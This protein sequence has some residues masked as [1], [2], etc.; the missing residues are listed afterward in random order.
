MR[1]HV[2][3]TAN[4]QAFAITPSMWA[5]ADGQGD[6]SFGE[7]EAEFLA[8][9]AEAEVLLTATNALKA[10]YPC[11]SPKLKMIFCASA[12]LDR[13]APFDWLPDGVA[14]LNN[15]GVHG[16]RAGEY[17]AMAL[18]MLAGKMPQMIA[19]QHAGRW[20]KHYASVLA[21]RHLTV[22]GTGDLG[23]SGARLARMFGMRTTGVRT[24]AVAHLD[25]DA[26]VAVDAI[27]S[28]LPQTD[29]LLL[30][31][32]LT[33]ETNGMIDRRRLELLPVGAGVI[34][35][36]RGALLE[37]DALC[38]LLDAGHLGGAVLDVFVPEPIPTGHRLW[39]TRNLVI[40]PH[41]AADDPATY[42]RHSLQIF[43]R[44]LAAFERGEPLPN[45]FD[46]A[47]G[48]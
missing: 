23:S 2:Q 4:D 39:T 6:V 19:A 26:V 43:L 3:N 32:P 36:G 40:T 47:R 27:D 14:L 28:V 16:A 22:V 42:A 46:T 25:F 20:E 34:N 5:A 37:Q 13:L 31:A 1:I 30:A 12:G 48:Y 29:F 44:N 45:R 17:A 24:R 15:R 38:D 41:V 9:L 7:T 8:G 10:Y 11:P 35:I 21:G 33:P 18:L